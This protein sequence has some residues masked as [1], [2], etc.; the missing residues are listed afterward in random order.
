MV[1]KP[2]SLEKLQEIVTKRF[3]ASYIYWYNT[4]TRTISGLST[5]N[6]LDF[7]LSIYERFTGITSLRVV[8]SRQPVTI[9]APPTDVLSSASPTPDNLKEQ[10]AKFTQRSQSEPYFMRNTTEG[11]R[12]SPDMYFHTYHGFRNIPEEPSRRDSPPPGFI[13]EPSTPVP[14][15]I[16]G[17]EGGKF[18]PEVEDDDL[19]NASPA[20]IPST[21]DMSFIS[22]ENL[23]ITGVDGLLRHHEYS[24]Y[25][26][27]EHGAESLTRTYPREK[28]YSMGELPSHTH[29]AMYGTY[30]L[31]PPPKLH[32]PLSSHYHHKMVP[33]SSDSRR[34][35]DSELPIQKLASLTV[36]HKI[37]APARWSKGRLLG[38]GAFGQVFLC[39]DLDTQMDMAVKVVDID[40]IENIKPSLDSLKM[41]KEVRSFETE[42]QLLKNIH[43]ERVVGYYGTER[44]EGKLF[45][46][47]EY[48]AGGSIY[49]HLKN[50]G[51]LSEALTRKYTRQI[52]E[53]VAFL[54][55]MKIVHRDIK[56]ANILRDSNGNVKLA[57]F[58]ASKRLQTIR[59]GIGSVHGTPYWMAP[60][61]IKGDDPYTFKAD[62]WSVGATVVEMLKCRPPWSDFEPTAAMFKI[63]MNDTKPD[64]PPHC[65]E[66]AHNFIELCFIKDK[67]E[68]PSAMDLLS[69]SFCSVFPNT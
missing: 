4:E 19:D 66:Q 52:L 15:D 22:E 23:S 5:Q 38:T 18:I 57:D 14:L 10:V 30:P 25:D 43:H 37:T 36:S 39:T 7:A 59:S 60:E 40:H 67:N 13:D 2:V 58:G 8:L 42:V 17:K 29:K 53:G 55:G 45:I 27:K 46:F 11:F 47:M 64:L 16:G 26:D 56:G 44:R 51:A 54:H 41:S 50:T 3:G 34:L 28:S 1:K 6:E 65:S 49:Q 33:G 62:I 32:P 69:H 31:N 20:S 12:E 21:L 9:T 68:R 35:Q 48:L 63:V 61:V 24:L